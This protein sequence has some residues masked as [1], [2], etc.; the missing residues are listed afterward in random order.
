MSAGLKRSADKGVLFHEADILGK[1]RLRSYKV[2]Y[3]LPEVFALPFSHRA[4][5][6]FLAL[7]LACAAPVA[8]HAQSAPSSGFIARYLARVTATQALQPHWITPLITVTP[9]L[10]QELRTDIISQ[11]QADH[12]HLW[13]YGS[14][15]GV[16]VVPLKP[17][18]LIFNVPPYLQ[19]NS[20]TEDGFGDVSMLMKYRL[21]SRNEQHGDEIVTAF[22]AGSY[23]TGS[24][25]NGAKNAAISP[26]LAVGKGIGP[27][28]VQSTLGATLPVEDGAAAGRP[29]A[30]N[31]ALQYHRETHWWPE[32]EFNSTYF[33]GGEND[34][35]VQ[36]FISPGVVTRYKLHNRIGIALG[37]GMQIALSSY[38]SYNHAVVLSA[39]M[40]F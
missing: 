5:A 16:E 23:P 2:I 8:L 36:T 40:P 34:G 37:A 32:V 12:T 7:A 10:E 24:Y 18:E 35:R 30:W 27:I 11:P 29:I 28:D 3:S 22:V 39:R 19:H 31:T 6:S 25:S 9:L 17:I 1:Y 15:K 14:G 38:H 21:F 26:T 13:N 20:A 4:L 33:K